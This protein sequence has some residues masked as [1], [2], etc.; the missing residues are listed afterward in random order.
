MSL[1]LQ[2]AYIS[3]KKKE[4]LSRFDLKI[5][6]SERFNS[7][8]SEFHDIGSALCLSI[9]SISEFL[10]FLLGYLHG[11]VVYHWWRGFVRALVGYHF[12][13]HLR[14]FLSGSGFD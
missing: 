7:H 2:K 12:S 3:K 13:Q 4:V 6:R 1:S 14:S 10:F 5:G 11:V 8:A 9:G